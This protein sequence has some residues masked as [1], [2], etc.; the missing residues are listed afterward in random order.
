MALTG[1]MQSARRLLNH[2]PMKGRVPIV[3]FAVLLASMPAGRVRA[4]EAP[5]AEED[6]SKH[7]V[8]G[9]PEWMLSDR[10]VSE[11]PL[12]RGWTLFPVDDIFLPLLGDPKQPRSELSLQQQT[13]SRDEHRLVGV[14][15][16]GDTFGLARYDWATRDP[17][18]HT[19]IQASLEGMAV[20]Q[21]GYAG[22][23]RGNLLYVDFF[24]GSVVT[25]THDRWSLRGRYYHQS[26]HVGDEYLRNN[27]GF[28]SINLSYEAA[29]FIGSYDTG[30]WRTYGGVGVR[31][32]IR[33]SDIKRNDAH[34]GL[35]LRSP[36]RFF[37]IGRFIAGYDLKMHEVN[38]FLPDHSVVIGTEFGDTDN[39][40]R[41]FKIIF[42]YFHGHNFYGEFFR[43]HFV[44]M[45][46]GLRFSQ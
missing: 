14:F 28:R 33:P 41:R 36:H 39:N 19:S 44:M 11:H 17:K 21:V 25:F 43:Q 32:H 2:E 5:P 38:D 3:L 12:P 1:V 42:Q 10:P 27:P 18:P 23:I 31:T 29:E 46:L 35:E 30:I 6:H 15:F 8:L 26:S 20:P 22:K 45:S 16:L 37:Y 13:I 7:G 24:L 34:L 4:Q 40:R 9:L